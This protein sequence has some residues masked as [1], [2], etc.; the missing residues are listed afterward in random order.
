M[1]LLVKLK[2]SSR[3]GFLCISENDKVFYESDILSHISFTKMI[4]F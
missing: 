2:E 3:K 4:V 1:I